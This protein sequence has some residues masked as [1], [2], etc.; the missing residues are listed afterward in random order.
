MRVL[1][2]KT[3]PDQPLQYGSDIDDE[4]DKQQSF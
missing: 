3:I 1:V 4:K 2:I